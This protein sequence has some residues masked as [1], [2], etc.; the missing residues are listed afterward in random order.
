MGIILD[1]VILLVFLLYIVKCYRQPQLRGGLETVA[2]LVALAMAV[3]ISNL[4]SNLAYVKLFRGAI[5]HNLDKVVE[6]TRMV[7][8]IHVSNLGRVL[9]T[10]PT[11][12]DFLVRISGYT[13]GTD[14]W[15]GNAQDL[16]KDGTCTISTVIG[17][18]DSIMLALIKYGVEKSH[19]FKI[20]EM[21]RKGKGLT[22]EFEAEMRAANVP[23]WYIGSC[24]KIK[25][26]FPKA[27]AAAY[28]IAAMRL[29]WY[30]VYYPL[31]YY[32]TYMSVRGED[33]DTV[34]IING[35]DAVKA[36]MNAIKAKGND[37]TAK[38][39]GT[40]TSMQVVNEMMARGVEF[41][42]VDIYKSHASTY[43]IE[44]GKIRL[45]FASMSG[46]GGAAAIALMKARD[47]GQGEYM[48]RE[49]L[50]QRSGVS[51]SVIESLAACGAL[52]G[53]P[54]STQMRFFSM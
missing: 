36:C 31:Q 8:G 54:E 51:K 5:A 29:A 1:I 30:K 28:V 2:Y 45:P 24:K 32:A 16:I 35:R 3:P 34:A 18:R 9:D 26:M 50:Q 20:M 19:A 52:E 43:L 17:T 37:A 39:E 42:P 4:A 44:D 33:L 13:H 15:L 23:D 12:F 21:V 22:P 49:D 11:K 46:T 40:Y 7:S 48:S 25:Y 38:E 14:V 27:H 6:E 47:D 10:M 41:L 53:L